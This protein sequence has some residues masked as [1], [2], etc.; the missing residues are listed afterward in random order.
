MARDHSAVDFDVV[1]LAR[2]GQN[3]WTVQGRPQGRKDSA[4]TADGGA[5]VGKIAATGAR[6]SR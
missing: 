6:D 4:L 3:E 2:H 5:Q 1:Y